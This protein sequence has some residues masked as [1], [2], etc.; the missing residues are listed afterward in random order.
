MSDASYTTLLTSTVA[1]GVLHVALNRP[2]Q[3]NAMNKVF[4]RE[5]LHL[6]TRLRTDT[7]TRCIIIS[8]GVSP[9]FTAGLDLKDFASLAGDGEDKDGARRALVFKELVEGMQEAFSA[10]ERCPQPVI[11]AVRG[12]CIGAGLDL[13]TACDIRLASPDAF[14]SLKEVDIGLAADVGTLQRLPKVVGNDSWVR[15]IAYT[16]RNFDAAEA[17]RMGLARVVEGGPDRLMAEAVKLATLIASK[18]PIAVL[19]TK[20][21]LNYSRDHTVAEGLKYV[22]VWN[23]AMTQT[24]DIPIAMQ[25]TLSK[26]KPVFSKL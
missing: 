18:S 5:C 19:G 21:V 24:E 25:A 1:P 10:V 23:M 4:W 14:F 2:A 6:F 13:I 26:T 8:G 20:E 17:E 3:R 11:A 15:E 7:S 22:A 12:A 9:I 16:A